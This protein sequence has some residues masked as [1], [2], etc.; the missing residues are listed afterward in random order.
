MSHRR[1]DPRRAPLEM[2][3]RRALRL[4]ADSIEPSADGLERIRSKITAGPPAP[5]QPSGWAL[6][7]SRYLPLLPRL[8][9]LPGLLAALS[10][11]ARHLEPIAMR[12][13]YAF[14]AVVD[15]LW[16]AFADFMERFR[17]EDGG[18]GWVRWL[19]PAAA[20]A[21]AFLV[22][23]GLSF[24]VT[25]VPPA[26]IQAAGNNTPAAGGGS[27]SGAPGQGHSSGVNGAGEPIGQSG[28]TS[29]T[30]SSSC[31]A[32]PASASPS[33]SPSPSPSGTSSPT[34]SPSP[35]SS[36]SPSPSGSSTDTSSP[37]PSPSPTDS[38]ATGQATQS[39]PG[40]PGSQPGSAG[41]KTMPKPNISNPK[42][43]QTPSPSASGSHSPCRS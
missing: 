6:W 2:T 21:A 30:A 26:L 7:R 19:R 43:A 18:T 37:S 3:L 13:W 39:P 25:A 42:T 32:G 4:A 24:A 29:P 17:P 31:K 8:P 5:L 40:P 12:M 35:S 23:T 28:T 36:P 11:A 16:Y 38:G 27:G 41:A 33:A 34:G 20:I 15:R 10:A 1:P 22:V 9:G 14:C